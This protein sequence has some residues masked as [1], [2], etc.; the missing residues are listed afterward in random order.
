MALGDKIGDIFLRANNMRV[1]AYWYPADGTPEVFLCS[2]AQS[3][4]N[5]HPHLR[6][7]FI[8]LATEVNIN[9]GRRASGWFSPLPDVEIG[10]GEI[11]SIV[12]PAD[13]AVQI[14]S[15]SL[16]SRALGSLGVFEPAEP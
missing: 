13:C 1:D 11:S 12:L 6:E 2:I 4:Y 7:L 3:A 8:E 10:G 9:R 5:D 15:I 16:G 14:T